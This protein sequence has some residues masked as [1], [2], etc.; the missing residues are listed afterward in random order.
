M[1]G[2]SANFSDRVDQE[3]QFMAVQMA[4][5]KRILKDMGRQ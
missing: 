3:L 4:V 2:L 1:D 5:L